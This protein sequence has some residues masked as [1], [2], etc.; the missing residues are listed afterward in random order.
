MAF[1]ALQ[2]AWNINDGI[3]VD[4]H[5]HRMT[6]RLGWHKTQTAEQTR[7]NLQSWLPKEVRDMLGWPSLASEFGAELCPM[8]SDLA[9]TSRYQQNTCWLR[10]SHLCARRSPVRVSAR[11]LF[12]Q[13]YEKNCQ[14]GHLPHLARNRTLS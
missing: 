14:G 7:L 11:L 8:Q 3:G 6:N 1:L 13:C 5:V 12:S 10:A 9:A 4:V 2:S